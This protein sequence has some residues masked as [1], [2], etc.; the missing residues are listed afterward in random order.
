MSFKQFKSL[1]GFSLLELVISIGL[2][3]IMISAILTVI[4][5]LIREQQNINHKMNLLNI[6]RSIQAAFADTEDCDCNFINKTF[7]A[8]KSDAKLDLSEIKM[9]CQPNAGVLVKTSAAQIAGNENLVDRIFLTGI[10]PSSKAGEYVSWL[11]VQPK[12]TPTGRVLRPNPIYFRFKTDVSSPDSAK[13]ITGCVSAGSLQ[14]GVPPTPANIKVSSFEAYCNLKW[15][16]VDPDEPVSYVTY[17]VKSSYN[18]GEAATKGTVVCTTQGLECD[19]KFLG[20]PH[21]GKPVYF[22]VQAINP[23]G[24]SAPIEVSCASEMAP[25]Q[26]SFLTPFAGRGENMQNGG[27]TESGCTISVNDN[28]HQNQKYQLNTSFRSVQLEVKYTTDPLGGN[29]IPSPGCEK[30]PFNSG[31]FNSNCTISDQALEGR[32]IN[33]QAKRFDQY[34]NE[35][36]DSV[37]FPCVIPIKMRYFS[38]ST[39]WKVPP[40]VKKIRVSMMPASGGGA[41]GPILFKIPNG[42]PSPFNDVNSSPVAYTKR[43]Q[44]FGY[45]K[46]NPNKCQTILGSPGKDGEKTSFGNYLSVPGSKGGL[47]SLVPNAKDEYLT[48]DQNLDKQIAQSY[49]GAGAENK[50]EF[51]Y[52]ELVNVTPGETISITIGKGGAGGDGAKTAP[53]PKGGA[54]GAGGIAAT[55]GA[56]GSDPKKENY[57]YVSSGGGGWGPQIWSYTG[58]YF[59]PIIFAAIVPGGGGYGPGPYFYFSHNTPYGPLWGAAAADRLANQ[60]VFQTGGGPHLQAISAPAQGGKPYPFY[61]DDTSCFYGGGGGAGASGAV[62]IFD[63]TT[64]P[65]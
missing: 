37:T 16:K 45:C 15:D 25:P 7:D 38:D 52:G 43:M 14:N 59:S 27:T 51:Y 34:G 17:L 56:S 49:P 58:S 13:V 53:C 54:G 55:Q 50:G 57:F 28:G 36:K 40:Q 39:T 5:N 32:T 21:I 48:Y 9:S 11:Q 24:K 8:T 2:M 41:G 29:M 10:S 35:S 46:I 23:V 65:K 60:G 64:Y 63:E 26:F 4:L 42:E 6:E 3:T 20:D 22:S 19:Y 47:N 31:N 62:L 18:K 33:V 30:L 61:A 44:H 1:K 12:K